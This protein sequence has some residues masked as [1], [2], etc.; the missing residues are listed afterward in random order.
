[1]I[2]RSLLYEGDE[3]SNKSS[4]YREIVYA[5]YNVLMLI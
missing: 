2:V 3:Y 1:M 5:L 4:I